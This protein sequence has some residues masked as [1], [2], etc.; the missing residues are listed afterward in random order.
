ME[1]VN[2]KVSVEVQEAEQNLDKII[3]KADETKEHLEDINDTVDEGIPSVEGLDKAF[4]NAFDSAL[5]G[6]GPLGTSLKKLWQSIKGAK[7]IIDATNKTAITGLKGVKAAIAATGV[8]ILI[9]ALGEL[10]ANWDKVSG[11]IQRW[12]PW[13]TKGREETEALVKANDDLIEA[14]QKQNGEIDYQARLMRALGSSEKEVINYKIKETQALQ[15]NTEAQIK[16]TEAKIASMRAH[17]WFRRWITGENK[18]IK[19]MEESLESLRKEQERLASSVTKLSQDLTIEEAKSQTER[20]K[21]AKKG[22]AERVK[23]AE[24]EAK[25]I[26]EAYKK[27]VEPAKNLLKDILDETKLK[28]DTQAIKEYYNS[29]TDSGAVTDEVAARIAEIKKKFAEEYEVIENAIKAEQDVL[30]SLSPLKNS[31]DPKDLELYQK[32]YDR[33]LEKIEELTVA[34]NYIIRKSNID[35]QNE[36]LKSQEDIYRRSLAFQE[37]IASLR[38]DFEST[39]ISYEKLPEEERNARLYDLEQQRLRDH[40]TYLESL[41]ALETQGTEAYTN[42]QL[43]ILEADNAIVAS[44]DR[45][46]AEIRKEVEQEISLWTDAAQSIASIF[47][48]IAQA[49]EERIQRQVEN[50]EITEEVAKRQFETVKN[51]QYA[52]TWINT[53][54]GMTAA[55]TAPIMQSA[56]PPGWIAAAAQAASLLA[57]GIA[58]TIKIRNTKFGGGAS[59]GGGGASA[60]N[61]GVTPI[62]VTDDIQ[63]SPSVLAASQSPRDQRVYILEGDIQ[64]S[65]R[66][67]EVRESNS[68]F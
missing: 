17:S 51:W 11:A 3:D 18:D 30:A 15:A 55:L 9:L 67:V 68:T 29:F 42:L 38:Y 45:R 6:L 37:D 54:A 53:L 4:E 52:E 60:P 35:T 2:V 46:R 64:D 23:T 58:Q 40:K 61:V 26:I 16:E 65:N 56:G 27:A 34:K 1:D 7:P 59:G 5:E 21:T 39:H 25:A 13:V 32:A 66:K 62:E 47:G 14:N 24:E 10:Y 63:Q 28:E 20:T 19:E 8:G 43:D 22:S 33:Y 44:Q 36:V 57:N 48:T 41:L 12:I 50:G 31:E 49:E